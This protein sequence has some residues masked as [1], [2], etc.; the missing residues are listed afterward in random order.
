LVARNVQIKDF[1]LSVLINFGGIAGMAEM[2]IQ[3]HLDA[4]QLLPALPKAW[5]KGTVKGLRARGDFEID[6]DWDAGKLR[7]ATVRSDMGGTCRIRSTTPVQVIGTVAQREGDVLVLQRRRGSRTGWW[8]SRYP[9][10][11][12]ISAS[13]DYI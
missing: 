12:A 4:I 8:R 9:Q 5:A 10:A 11:F 2:L 13:K 6:M 7:T 3:S 1:V